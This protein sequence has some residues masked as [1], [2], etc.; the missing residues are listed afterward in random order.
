MPPKTKEEVIEEYRCAS[1]EDA[2]VAVIARKGVEHATLQEIADEAGIAKGTIYVY[3]RDRE[4]LLLKTAN[5]AFERLITELEPAFASTGPLATKLRSVVMRQLQFFD[6]NA[7]LFRASM[8]LSRHENEAAQRKRAG[9]L[10]RYADRVET[11]FVEAKARGEI[12]DLDPAA[13]AAL[14]RDCL[15]G[16]LVRRLERKSR[17]PRED[18]VEFIASILLRGIQTSESKTAEENS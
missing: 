14:Y 5:R 11:M 12:R 6:E 15:R 9:A 8:A 13:V 3:F 7:E 1:I 16:V 2:A 10:R 18:E 4:E 17:T